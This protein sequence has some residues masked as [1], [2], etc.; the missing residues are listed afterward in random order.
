MIDDDLLFK[1]NISYYYDTK[2]IYET[3]IVILSGQYN[4]CSK[5]HKKYLL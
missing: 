4:I 2:Q 5:Y 3:L 1:I